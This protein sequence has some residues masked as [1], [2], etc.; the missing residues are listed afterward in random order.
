MD[1]A[2]QGFMSAMARSSTEPDLD[3]VKVCVKVTTGTSR[4]SSFTAGG[5]GAAAG[6]R[7]L[8]KVPTTRAEAPT[9][10]FAALK[11]VIPSVQL[12]ALQ[13]TICSKPT[14]GDIFRNMH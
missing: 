2:A 7:G 12:A 6:S 14:A 1:A 9:A 5:G 11:V 4:I 3:M 10:S 8:R 13:S